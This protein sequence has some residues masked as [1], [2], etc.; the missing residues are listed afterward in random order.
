MISILHRY[1]L[2]NHFFQLASAESLFWTPGIPFMK[3][4]FLFQFKIGTTANNSRCV[5]VYFLHRS[6]NISVYKHPP[7]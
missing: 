1:P 5:T 7:K 2:D 3:A 6:V 4:T